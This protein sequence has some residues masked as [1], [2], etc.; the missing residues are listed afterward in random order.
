MALFSPFAL[1]TA[2]D[3]W[4]K[5]QQ[6][7]IN[8]QN[9]QRINDALQTDALNR[10]IAQQKLQD[11]L[12]GTQ[13]AGQ[14]WRALAQQ[15]KQAPAPAPGQ[16]SAQ[17]PAPAAAPPA[18]PTQVDVPGA[19]TAQFTPGGGFS[20]VTTPQQVQRGMDLGVIPW[21]QGAAI[22]RDMQA[23]GNLPAQGSAAVAPAPAPQPKPQPAQQDV[24]GGLP[25]GT[26]GRVLALAQNNQVIN[27][28]SR[29]AA[30]LLQAHPN[31]SDRQLD[32]TM[33]QLYP[34]LSEQSKNML[35]LAGLS[36]TE[37]FK[38]VNVLLRQQSLGARYPGMNTGQM[39]YSAQQLATAADM[40]RNGQTIPMAMKPWV[41]QA[42][43]DLAPEALAGKAKQAAA[44]ASAVAPVKVQQAVS[45]ATATAAPKATGSALTQVQK[46]LSAIEPAYQ[47]LD[48]NFAGLV[49][50][51]KQYGLGPATPVNALLNRMRKMG[52][53]NYTNY[54]IFLKGVQKEFG[55]VLQGATGAR[56]VSVS[57]MKDAEGTLSPNMT[58]GQLEAA[59]KALMTEGGNVL[60]SLRTQKQSLT[61]QLQGGGQAQAPSQ[62]FQN[63][64][65]YTDANGN[66]ARYQDGQWI[67]VQ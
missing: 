55:K 57:A 44:T 22:V 25:T 47:A 30:Q 59:Q 39:P 15:P 51:A 46:N 65:V 37:M 50:A 11:Y 12:S 60:N 6:D 31:M 53:P 18:A 28:A 38:A 26:Y 2:G 3:V 20:N 5:N 36:N 10:Q 63:G 67:P 7:L 17:Q 40:L 66:K 34:A 21:Q 54:E 24:S 49:N 43:P 42:Y 16:N 64:A 4:Q 61:Q 8:R 62:Q 13:G 45:T 1:G 48:A 41:Y 52:D 9:Q 14:Y 35:Q 32:L 19:S 56:G 58:L 33:Q 29:A 23:R 27:L